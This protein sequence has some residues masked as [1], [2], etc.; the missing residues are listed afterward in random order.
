MNPT[1]SRTSLAFLVGAAVTVS[2]AACGS[3]GGSSDGADKADGTVTVWQYYGDPST[4]TGGPFYDVLKKYDAQNDDV[5]VK[6]R[7]IPFDDFNR[8]LLQA[9]AAH[10][11]PD[12]ALINAFDTQNMAEAGVIEDLSSRV[13]K[14]GEQDAYFPTSWKT[15]Q[16]EGKT[17]GI[18]HLAD[19]YAVYYNKTLLDRAG[20]KPPT[21]WQEMEANA[22][23]LA[24]GDTFGLA[25][26]GI[27]G[28]EGATGL[29][30]R[31]LA[32]G[33]TV[34]KLDDDAGQKAL[35]SFKTMVDS[36]A[37][38]KGFLTWNE[39]DA[40]NQFAT[41]K[42]AMMINSATYVSVLRKEN[43]D[44]KW[45]VAL[46]PKDQERLT[47]L[48]AENLTIGKDSGDADDAWDLITYLQKPDVL[49]K[50]LPERNKLPARDDVT[51]TSD[52]PVRKVF[53]EQLKTAW[54]PEGDLAT[55][56]NEVFSV[57][58]E[59]LQATLSG[60]SAAD[61]AKSAQG[62]IDEALGN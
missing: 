49:A 48:S 29:V 24:G 9:A 41:G 32:A 11:L 12:V 55:H 1:F 35:T 40:K 37:L 18:P 5:K 28:A 47:F 33:G 54:A 38:S 26:S 42:A 21:T 22:A 27:E 23:K 57:L 62:S 15:T 50:Y 2:L 44:L 3:L 10:D 46:L 30:I 14:W 34:D 13:K 53:A 6:I 25:V 45:G 31:D 36:G 20:L 56:S 7:F 19:A 52:D 43:P 51:G 4:P 8:T 16:V 58:Q 59:A 39:E 17:Y 60:T 61:A